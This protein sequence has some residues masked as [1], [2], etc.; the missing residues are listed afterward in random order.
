MQQNKLAQPVLPDQKNMS[1][2]RG[3]LQIPL[4]S[5]AGLAFFAALNRMLFSRTNLYKVLSGK[6]NIKHLNNSQWF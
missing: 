4:F 3:A 2:D 5:A 6:I 1:E